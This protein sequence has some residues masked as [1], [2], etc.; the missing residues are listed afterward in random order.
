MQQSR[1][2]SRC[3]GAKADDAHGTL[4]ERNAGVDVSPHDGNMLLVDASKHVSRRWEKEEGDGGSWV[5]CR[6]GSSGV[7][8]HKVEPRCATAWG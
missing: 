3:R 8:G 2:P 7:Y 5:A 4:L 1:K 6:G